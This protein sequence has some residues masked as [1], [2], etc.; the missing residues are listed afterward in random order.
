MGA[1]YKVVAPCKQ[2]TTP[3]CPFFQVAASQMDDVFCQF[4]A[5]NEPLTGCI[6]ITERSKAISV[7]DAQNVIR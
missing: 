1:I 3:T 5:Y 4:M 6:L 7:E 2:H